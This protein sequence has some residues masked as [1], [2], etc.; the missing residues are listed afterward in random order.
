MATVAK[1]EELSNQFLGPNIEILDKFGDKNPY[2][3]RYDYEVWRFFSP[4]ILHAGFLH[5]FVRS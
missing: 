3:M 1:R 4:M 2:K 5:I